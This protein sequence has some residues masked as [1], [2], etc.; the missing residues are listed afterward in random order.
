[1]THKHTKFEQIVDHIVEEIH[2]LPK[3]TWLDVVKLEIL[4]EDFTNF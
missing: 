3:Q 2:V 4:T 1:M